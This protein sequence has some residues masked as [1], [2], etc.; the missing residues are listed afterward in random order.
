MGWDGMASAVL[1]G[2]Q[3]SPSGRFHHRRMADSGWRQRNQNSPATVRWTKKK[4]KGWHGMGWERGV[5]GQWN[6]RGRYPAK[7]STARFLSQARYIFSN[8]FFL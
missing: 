6:R 5:Y 8:A 4:K 1:R 7:Q 2:R 3:S